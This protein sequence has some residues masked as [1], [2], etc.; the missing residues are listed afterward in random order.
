M[1]ALAVYCATLHMEIN[2]AK[3]KVMVVSKH[4]VRSPPVATV[5][6]CNGLPVEHVDTFKYLGL[7]FHISGG[8]SHLIAPMKAKAAR[9]WGVVQQRHSQLQCGNTVNLMLSLL[10][11]IL[12]PALHYGCE[13]WGMHT[14][15]GEAKAARA[16]LQS[17][18]DRFLRR[19]CGVKHAPS[20]VLL[21]ELALSPLQVFWWQ[22]TLEFW[23]T[24]AA[25]P[26]GS[27]FHTN[28][29]DNI[30]DAFHVGR[31][32]K[33]F[34]SSVATCLQSVGHSMPRDSD[35]V[36]VMEVAAIIKALREHLQGT[37]S[38]ALHCPRAAPS[39]GVVSCTYYNWFRPFSKRRRYCQL[40]VSGRHMQRFLQV[41]LGSHNLPIVA[42]R[43][44]G[45]QHVARA[46]RVCTHCGGIAVADELHMI[47]ECP[48]LQPLRLQYAAL[49]TPDTNTMRSFFAQQDHMRVF[50][51]SWIVLTS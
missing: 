1:D 4:S 12:V 7:H 10:Q 31:G 41:R 45:D 40:P 23:N 36:P 38:H 2:V 16:A 26:A 28:L 39:V 35:V 48:V 17:I 8:I 6:T 24:I 11:S 32:A 30:H 34:S 14:P 27:L 29:L 47:H 3:T 51:L 15:T 19:I 25:S 44:S 50:I 20:A 13:I 43:F 33:N 46:D 37:H 42:G 22:Q 5:F 9:S 18:Y 49:F 21:E